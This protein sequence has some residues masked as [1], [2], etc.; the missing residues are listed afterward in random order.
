MKCLVK[1]LE[2]LALDYAVALCLFPEAYTNKPSV[3]SIVVRYPYSTN[4]LL[5][6]PLMQRDKIC[7]VWRHKLGYWLAYE[8]EMFQIGPTQL[9]AAMRCLVAE[10]FGDEVEIPEELLNDL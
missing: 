4:Y 9:I 1:D 7:T 6:G 5:G 10:K 2:G 8:K 3:M